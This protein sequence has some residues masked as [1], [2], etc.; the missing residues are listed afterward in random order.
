LLNHAMLAHGVCSLT[1]YIDQLMHKNKE[2]HRTK[3]KNIKVW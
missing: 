2:Y 3:I 1:L